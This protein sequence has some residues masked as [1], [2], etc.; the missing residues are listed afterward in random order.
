MAT[1]VEEP[2]FFILIILPIVCVEN[3]V[4]NVDWIFPRCIKVGGETRPSVVNYRRPWV[5]PILRSDEEKEWC[6]VSER[7]RGSWL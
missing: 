1:R 5:K 6:D 3:T 2:I 4:K 7:L